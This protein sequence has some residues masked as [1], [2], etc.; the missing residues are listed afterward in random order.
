MMQWEYMSLYS[1][2]LTEEERLR[3]AGDEGWEMIAAV[4]EPGYVRDVGG[5]I[6]L[7]FK[8]P[9]RVL[10]KETEDWIPY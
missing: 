8:R 1:N 5:R 6:V 9:K 2:P 7:Y 10:P 4:F 3:R